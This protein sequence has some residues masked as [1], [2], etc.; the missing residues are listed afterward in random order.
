MERDKGKLVIHYSKNSNMQ[1][2]PKCSQEVMLDDN[3]CKECGEKINFSRNVSYDKSTS[4]ASFSIS[5]DSGSGKSSSFS[6]IKVVATPK[7][8]FSSIPTPFVPSKAR[9]GGNITMSLFFP[10]HLDNPGDFNPRNFVIE[11]VSEITTLLTGIPSQRID[12]SKILMKDIVP[13][14]Y[15]QQYGNYM[16]ENCKD[17]KEPTFFNI[18]DYIFFG[19]KFMELDMQSAMWTNQKNNKP[20]LKYTLIKNIRY[21]DKDEFSSINPRIQLLDDV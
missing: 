13:L 15:H 1:K 3:F 18:V 16:Y 7:S 8:F 9:L 10:Q 17:K 14:E 2:C 6:K 4:E 11:G 19:T 12:L 5:V 21:L 20:Y